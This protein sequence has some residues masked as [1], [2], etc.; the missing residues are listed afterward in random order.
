MS[1]TGTTLPANGEDL[2]TG[3]FELELNGNKTSKQSRIALDVKHAID[4]LPQE[5]RQELEQALAK[6][7]ER[8]A[9][10]MLT[11]KQLEKTN[12]SLCKAEAK[13][14]FAKLPGI[15][16]QHEDIPEN[17]NT[18]AA[19]QTAFDA[20]M[21]E[22]RLQ[23]E[24]TCV[25]AMTAANNAAGEELTKDCRAELQKLITLACSIHADTNIL[26]LREEPSTHK[27]EAIGNLRLDVFA[28]DICGR[29]VAFH[30]GN[31]KESLNDA[32]E[33]ARLP[34]QE[35]NAMLNTAINLLQLI[36]KGDEAE[37]IVKTLQLV[38]A[39]EEYKDNMELECDIAMLTGIQSVLT[40][41][42]KAAATP[43]Q[44]AIGLMTAELDSGEPQER[45]AQYHLLLTE[46]T[47]AFPLGP[48]LANYLVVHSLKQAK[49]DM[50]TDLMLS[51]IRKR[52]AEDESRQNDKVKKTATKLA[53]A[54]ALAA[55]GGDKVKLNQLVQ[56]AVAQQAPGNI[57]KQGK[58]KHNGPERDGTTFE[59]TMGG[60]RTKTQDQNNELSFVPL[61]QRDRFKGS[62]QSS[63]DEHPKNEICKF[64]RNGRCKR[65]DK[66]PYRH[67]GN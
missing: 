9:N 19:A 57:G 38:A 53:D 45:G 4:V 11:A 59:I 44:K 12:D 25:A 21:N 33:V 52:R 47:E 18:H 46:A 62:K 10:N 39:K 30:L 23:Y 36:S 54:V 1:S 51:G 41:G 48:Q 56:K 15:A 61:P 22:I 8:I 5:V 66:C 27:D 28:G 64:W 43:L 14:G 17:T 58:R 55:N 20:K 16:F 42:L 6:A 24:K 37:G 32:M 26:V 34:L 60:K 7:T 31:G 65:Q 13:P 2:V 35:W 67:S 29:A 49:L 40:E 50:Q 3:F 63:N